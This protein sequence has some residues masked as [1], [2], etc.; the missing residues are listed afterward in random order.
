MIVTL[1][2]VGGRRVGARAGGGG[3]G[4]EKKR[5]SILGKGEKLIKFEKKKVFVHNLPILKMYKTRY[6]FH[7]IYINY[8][9]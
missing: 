7:Y 9:Q 6:P 3:E 4:R 2:N 5:N 8:I 1:V